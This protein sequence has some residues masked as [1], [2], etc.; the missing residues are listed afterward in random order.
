ME[1]SKR[2]AIYARVSTGEQNVESQ[3]RDLREYCDLRRWTVVGEFKDEGISGSVDERPGV[4]ECKRFALKG[5]ADVVLVWAFDRFA[6]STTH[7]LHTLEELRTVHVDF[8]SYRQNIDTTTPTGKM[9]FTFL[10]AIA[11]FER[12]LIRQRVM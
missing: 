7:L 2:V 12:E 8:V 5:R 11:E 1:S 10:A 4:L 9:V 6:R 3:L